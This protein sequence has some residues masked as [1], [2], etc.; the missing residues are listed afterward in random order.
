M[1]VRNSSAGMDE[2]LRA[3]RAREVYDNIRRAEEAGW[4]LGYVGRRVEYAREGN[5]VR[6]AAD[7]YQEALAGLRIPPSSGVYGGAYRTARDSHLGAYE[8][9][10]LPGMI[11]VSEIASSA[12]GTIHSAVGSNVDLAA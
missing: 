7:E 11:D 1:I 10:N 12:G 4:V 3:A 5:A 9:M 8:G 2:A 6:R